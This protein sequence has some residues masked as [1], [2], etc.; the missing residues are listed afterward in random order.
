MNRQQLAAL[1]A[2]AFL[3]KNGLAAFTDLDAPNHSARF[4]RA[5]MP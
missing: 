4:Y 1:L 5:T 2:I 3:L